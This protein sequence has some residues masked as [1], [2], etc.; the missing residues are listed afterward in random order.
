MYP[1]RF[2]TSTRVN[3]S[4]SPPDI[5]HNVSDREPFIQA[6]RDLIGEEG[7]FDLIALGTLHYK[8]AFKMYS[9]AYNLDPKLAN[10]VTKQIDKYEQAMKH[11]EDDEKDLIDIYDYVD[12]DKYEYLIDG[13]QQYMGIVDN[14]KAHPCFTKD[15][16]V[17]TSIGYKK[18]SEIKVGDMVLTHDNSFKKVINTMKNESSDIYNLDIIGVPT[19]E[20]TGNHPFYTSKRKY[21]RDIYSYKKAFC[22]RLQKP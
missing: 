3:E 13:C 5:D 7:T 2:L 12:K 21:T 20:V 1:E 15:E 17:M 4:K 9:R 18:I 10:E 8:S 11:A 16:L 6:Q 22:Q 14:I 19:I